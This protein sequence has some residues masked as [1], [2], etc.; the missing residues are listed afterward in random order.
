MNLDCHLQTIEAKRSERQRL[1]SAVTQNKQ[2]VDTHSL[3]LFAL[4]FLRIVKVILSRF[5]QAQ[6]WGPRP[7]ALYPNPR[8]N[9]ALLYK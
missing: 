5:K 1:M 7:T 4:C 3:T 6:I 8:N 2:H 9:E